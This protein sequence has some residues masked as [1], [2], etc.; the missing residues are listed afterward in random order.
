[1]HYNSLTHNAIEA[2]PP[3]ALKWKLCW[4]LN[5]SEHRNEGEGCAVTHCT[6]YLA[7]LVN[8]VFIVCI[9]I[10]VAYCFWQK[11][12]ML[13]KTVFYLI[14]IQKKNCIIVK[15]YFNLKELYSIENFSII[16]PVF[17]VTWSFRNL[18][19][20]LIWCL[21]IIKYY[22]YYCLIFCGNGEAFLLGFLIDKTIQKHSI[23]LK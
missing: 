18:S 22:C 10:K 13:T 11:S 5:S 7:V 19:N 6:V 17:S 4:F 3:F 21:V 16:T 1:M 2:L 8:V 9:C 20:G 23:Y 14:Q 15:Y 12:I